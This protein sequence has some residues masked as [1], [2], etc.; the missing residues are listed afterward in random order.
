MYPFGAITFAV[1]KDFSASPIAGAVTPWAAMSNNHSW[2][3][4]VSVS[5]KGI[6]G[7]NQM[8]LQC[9]RDRGLHMRE[10]SPVGFGKT[11]LE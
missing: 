4:K 9:R 10:S 8:K 11:L 6:S 5:D 3:A 1:L 2:K 7:K